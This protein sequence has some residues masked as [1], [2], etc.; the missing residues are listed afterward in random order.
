VGCSNGLA[1]RPLR[2]K[3]KITTVLRESCPDWPLENRR[4]TKRQQAKDSIQPTF[5]DTVRMAREAL[6][7]SIEIL[8]EETAIIARKKGS[9]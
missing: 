7:P 4:Q 5:M 9:T 6:A 1:S 3:R 8:A 2:S